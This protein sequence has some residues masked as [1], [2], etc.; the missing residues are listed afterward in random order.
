MFFCLC[1]AFFTIM[2]SSVK[3]GVFVKK[4]VVLLV[5]LCVLLSGVC[6]AETGID[7]MNLTVSFVDGTMYALPMSLDDAAAAGLN[8]PSDLYSLEAGY[9]YSV[10]INDREGD[11][12]EFNQFTA[13][14]VCN[15]DTPDMPWING[16]TISAANNTGASVAGITIGTTTRDEVVGA[17]GADAHGETEAETLNYFQMDNNI[18][19]S[20]EFD[21]NV[22]KRLILKNGLVDAY[23]TVYA[24]AEPAAGLPAADAM[25]LNQIIIRGKLYDG[26][27]TLNDFL[28][29]GW[30]LPSRISLEDEVKARRGNTV[31][32]KILTLYDGENMLSIQV[33]NK[34]EDAL[35]LADCCLLKVH[36]NAD[37]GADCVTV[38]NGLNVG[39]SYDDVI[40]AL[41]EPRT[42]SDESE[43]IKKLHY[44]LMI[45]DTYTWVIEIDTFTNKVVGMDIGL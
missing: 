4:L 5:M 27:A 25:E 20:V 45:M 21:G 1:Y 2:V 19:C 9:Y 39:S 30:K 36:L 3:E 37:W 17:L 38:A 34:T 41:G 33:G 22:V 29:A 15:P 40:A 32:S 12:E 44:N 24:P 10:Q 23:G 13:N 31:Y 35:P 8:I 26:S 43:G 42:M 18:I 14:V 16:L 28:N 7:L 11:E 6:Y